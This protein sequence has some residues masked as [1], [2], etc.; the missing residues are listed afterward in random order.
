MAAV[1]RFG[2]LLNE[3]EKIFSNARDILA[4]IGILYGCKTAL[5]CLNYL[6]QATNDHL[7]S[8]LSY[9]TD[10]KKRFGSWAGRKLS[11]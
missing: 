11:L 2:F 8:K 3:I 6:L 9:I 1:D 5:K 10:F 4:V 7:L